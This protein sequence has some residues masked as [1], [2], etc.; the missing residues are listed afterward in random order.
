LTG[1]AVIAGKPRPLTS[2][3]ANAIAPSH[4]ASG[5]ATV[6]PL[7]SSPMRCGSAGPGLAPPPPPCSAQRS[8]SIA[9]PDTAASALGTITPSA[10]RRPAP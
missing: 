10:S 1:G 5:G 4:S 3:C 7:A 6:A 9:A 2:A 8:A